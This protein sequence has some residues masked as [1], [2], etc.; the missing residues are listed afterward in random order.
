MA[1]EPPESNSLP[2]NF[3]STGYTSPDSKT[4]NFNFGEAGSSGS[5]NLLA[6]INVL[7]QPDYLNETYTYV[8]SCPTYVVGYSPAGVQ[9]MKGRCLYGGIRDL[10]ATLTVNVLVW[11]PADITAN[12]TGLTFTDIQ[13]IIAS[14]QPSNL[15]ASLKPRTRES[16]DLP[17]SAHGVLQ[18][19]LGMSLAGTHDPRDLYASLFVRS[20]TSTLLP[21]SIYG[22]IQKDFPASLYSMQY[23][24]LCST[25]QSVEPSDL[26]AYLKVWPQSLL[27]ASTYGWGSLD[28]GAYVNTLQYGELFANITGRDDMFGDLGVQLKGYGSS[29]KDLPSYLMTM[30]YGNLPAILR[31]TY[32]SSISSYI[33]AVPPKNLPSFLHAWH[34]RDL[35]GII[36]GTKYPGDLPA[37]ITCSGYWNNFP[38]Y[39]TGVRG[40]G[41]YGNLPTNIGVWQ[42]SNLSAVIAADAAPFLSAYINIIGQASNLTASIYPKVIRLTTVISI[43]TLV[44]KDLS[45]MINSPCFYTGVKNLIATIY[46]KFKGDLP[47]YIRAISYNYKLSL[48]PAKVGYSDAFLE[49]DKLPISIS[50]MPNDFYTFDK[51]RIVLNIFSADNQLGAY[52]RGTLRYAGLGAS[53]EGEEIDSYL[54]DGRIKN[55]ERY[56]DR[57]YDGVYISYQTIEMAFKSV[58]T[59]YYYSSSGDYAWKKDRLE[60]WMLDVKSYLPANTALRLKRRLNRATVLYDLRRFTTVDAAVRQAIDYVTEYPQSNLT[61]SIVNRGT[62]TYLSAS[63]NPRYVHSERVG[64]GSSINPVGDTVVVGSADSILKK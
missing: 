31:A 27:S 60:R 14:H 49:V 37:S 29:Q 28:L 58:V 42:P 54:F 59:D 32:L 43:P 17:A 41:A 45:A 61:A 30:Q 63:L 4:V 57:T 50:V 40:A 36:T 48:L 6:A 11:N 8:K 12:I 10:G 15:S 56:I 18:R 24:N 51:L 46:P 9:I 13:A 64:L 1:Y 38:A 53:I 62:F 22:W 47:A 25:L 52:I 21:A 23:G 5:G 35:Q 44:H 26:P 2:F 33:Y 3:T 39:I 55:R 19:D 20:R 16:D 7:Q 34:I